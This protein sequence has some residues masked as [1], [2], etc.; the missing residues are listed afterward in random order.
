[1][2]SSLDCTTSLASVTSTTLLITGLPSSIPAISLASYC[3]L[4]LIE[5]TLVGINLI[6]TF[7]SFGLR[8]VVKA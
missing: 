6:V 2:N 3:N 5:F 1:M 8:R 4:T 7:A